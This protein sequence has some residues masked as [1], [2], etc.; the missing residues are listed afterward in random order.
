[1]IE[2]PSSNYPQPFTKSSLETS[3]VHANPA[4]H[5][6]WFVKRVRSRTDT[7][8]GCITIIRFL[9]STSRYVLI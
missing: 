1:M 6:I 4:I 8:V 9:I 5:D 7:S 2:S 3:N